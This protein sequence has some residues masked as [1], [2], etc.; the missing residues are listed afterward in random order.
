MKFIVKVVELSRAPPGLCAL[1]S[2]GSRPAVAAY[3]SL[4]EA[5]SAYDAR[6]SLPVAVVGFTIHGAYSGVPLK[7]ET[8]FVKRERLGYGLSVDEH[9]LAGLVALDDESAG[10]LLVECW[11]PAGLR[12]G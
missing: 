6:G 11:R 1:N 9:L 3:S 10:T 7:E 5:L 12:D 2:A 8:H 4:T